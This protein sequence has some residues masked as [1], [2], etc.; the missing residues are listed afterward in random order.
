MGGCQAQLPI[1][2]IV[3][4]GRSI[5]PNKTR[6]SRPAE[7]EVVGT[8]SKDFASGNIAGRKLGIIENGATPT[9]FLLFLAK[10]E[11]ALFIGCRFR[12]YTVSSRALS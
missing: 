6:S 8:G 9:S 3:S 7:P 11:I 5:P 1:Q 12:A 2:L 4:P 10:E